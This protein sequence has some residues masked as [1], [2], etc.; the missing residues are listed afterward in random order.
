MNHR[1]HDAGATFALLLAALSTCPAAADRVPSYGLDIRPILSNA[2]FKCHGPDDEDRKGGPKGSGGL[3]LDTEEG[4]RASLGGRAAVVPGHAKDSELMARIISTD[5]DEVMPP[6]K[7]GSPLTPDE[8]KLIEAWINSGA[9]YTKHWS[10]VPPV[11]VT[12][13]RTDL[14][15]IDAFVRDRLKQ[16]GLQP[17]PE[18]DRA[19]L[20]RRLSFDLTGLPPSPEVVDAFVKDTAAGAY[21]RLVDQLLAS[22]AYGEHWARQWLD[23]ARYADSAGYAD[24]PAR[25]IWGYRDYVIRSF[26]ENKRFDQFTLEQIAGDLLPEPTEEQ[27]IATAFHRNT[28]TNSEGGTNDEEFRN[29]AVVDRV[30]TTMAVWMGTSMAC[31]QCH[32]HKY[33]PITQAEY[34]R[35]FAFLNNTADA[36]LRDEAPL[37]SFFPEEQKAKRQTLEASLAEVEARFTKPSPPLQAAADQWAS[38]FPPSLEWQTLKPHALT[39]QSGLA[40]TQEKDG[41]IAVAAG[42]TKDS[43]VI[44]VPATGAGTLTALRLEALPHETLPNKGPGHAAGNFVVTG[45]KAEVKPPRGAKEPQV[46]YVRIELPGKDKLLQLAEVQVFSKGVNVAPQGSATQKS[47]YADAAAARANDGNTAGEYAKGSVAHTAERTADPWWEVDLKSDQ[48]VSRIV[49]WNRSEAPE[50]LAG[51][52][53]VALDA[54]RQPVW[55]KSGNA[56]AAEVPFGLDG[57]REIPFAGAAAD[58][59]QAD[60]NEARV[61]AGSTIAKPRGSQAGWA[62]G[63]GQGVAHSLVLATARPVEIPAGSMLRITI[64]QQSAFAQHTLGRFR[65]SMTRSPEAARLTEIPSELAGILALPA[66]QRDAA[67][68]ARVTN[69]YLRELA[70]EMA[71]DREALAGFKKQLASLQPSTVP[72]LRELPEGKRRKTHLQIRGNYLNHGDELTEGVPM[73]LFPLPEGGPRNRLTLARWLVDPANPLTAR[74]IANRFWESLFGLGIVRTSEEFGA[75]GDAPTHPELLDWLAVDLVRGGWDIKR[76]IRLIVTSE[77]YRQSSKIASGMAERDPENRL[78]ARGP[79]VRLTAEMVRDQALATSGLLSPEMYGPSV[80]PVRPAL[81]LSAAFGG[82][83]DWQTSTGGDQHRR[84][85]YTEW[86]RTSPYPSMATFDAP[87]R[88]ICT[89]RRDRSNTPLQ[90]LVLLNDPVYVEAAQA[91]ARRLMA[92]ASAPEDV[93]REGFRRVLSRVPSGTE[94]KR[95]LELRQELLADY[96]KD[97]KKA[98]EMA[99][100]PIGP[101]PAGAD[102]NELAAWTAV[103][104]VLLNLDE[105]LLKR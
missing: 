43:Y 13:P 6:R 54:Q 42:A 29:A 101:L 63:G 3:R 18:A 27:R 86:R 72:I 76:F 96:R 57:T 31:A 100:V 48:P 12:P 103:A 39:S 70:P 7:S 77:T 58:F 105:T 82:G 71:A 4:A 47:T 75:Q 79:R 80:R 38:R 90:A 21:E 97:P 45:I 104:G 64:E 87:S 5:E 92:T 2:C 55:E 59:V 98:A 46:R 1:F 102:A 91:L 84:A 94:L 56:A 40:M 89:L 9:K 36:D 88:E 68:K 19:T 14:H 17:Q 37:L 78:L 34:F 44:E 53:I 61:I 24:D 74:V 52:R 33:D 50:R 83:L 62:I 8:V 10:Y 30:N 22:P 60:F 51:F 11:A 26:N 81:G 93:I 95:L 28:M 41:I 35:M 65:L 16:E 73:A 67:Q 15:P 69:Y 49:V 32:T 23:L 20:A 99:T 25:S 66:A 85:L